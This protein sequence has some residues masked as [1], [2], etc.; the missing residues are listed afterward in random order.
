M[1][2][3]LN[4]DIGEGIGGDPEALDAALL[5]VVTSVNVACGGHAG[6]NESM[7][8]VCPLAAERGVAIG[9]HISYPDREGFGRLP[10][11]IN[12]DELFESLFQQLQD[13]QTKA[14]AAGTAVTYIKPHGY[15]Y[16][17]PAGIDGHAS[18]VIDVIKQYARE[19]GK[20]LPV[21]GLPDSPLLEAAAEQGVKGVPEAFAD[22][23]YTTQGT[24]VP[25]GEPGAVVT[26]PNDALTRLKRLIRD[27]EIVSIDGT[28]IEVRARSICVHGDTPGAAIIARRLRA[29]IDADRVRITPFAPPPNK[30][31]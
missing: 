20:L 22:R 31:A 3:D 27:D 7:S 2:I 6:N 18:A 19:T 14:V 10:M 26:D 12:N 13:L 16:T 4:A 28:P 5:D 17:A 21:L 11:D 1:A 24:L 23:A 25:R 30:A 15:L 8:R 9:A 29:A